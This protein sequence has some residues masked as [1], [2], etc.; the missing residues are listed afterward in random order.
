M[1]KVDKFV[2]DIV[3]LLIV[4]YLFLF[5]WVVMVWSLLIRVSRVFKML[6][7]L[8]QRLLVWEFWYYLLDEHTSSRWF[9]TWVF[10]SDPSL[11]RFALTMRFVLNLRFQ[12]DLLRHIV[13]VIRPLFPL[14]CNNASLRRRPRPRCARLASRYL[15]AQLLR[16]VSIR[17]YHRCDR[18]ASVSNCLGCVAHRAI[19]VVVISSTSFL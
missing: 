3:Y 5:W 4:L 6:N 1:K 15:L 18:I 19:S 17:W 8:F 12:L 13:V 9:R 2:T 10:G 14:P 7:L 16:V 11:R